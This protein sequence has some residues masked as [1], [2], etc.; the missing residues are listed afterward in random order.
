MRSTIKFLVI[1]ASLMATIAMAGED[2]KRIAEGKELAFSRKKGN[3][4][5]CHMIPE[6]VSPGNIAPPL[7]AMKMRYPD[8]NRLF[9][10]VWDASER[11]PETSMPLFGRYE[12]LSKDEISKIVD[13]IHSL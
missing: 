6:G 8:K 2:S 12:I 10:Q 5:A 11:N 1:G 9:N 4:L 7:I 13:Y 3:C